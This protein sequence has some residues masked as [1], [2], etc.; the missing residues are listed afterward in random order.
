LPDGTKPEPGGR[1]NPDLTPVT[2]WS[3]Y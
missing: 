3:S 1:L 2:W